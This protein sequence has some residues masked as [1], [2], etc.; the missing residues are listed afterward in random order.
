VIPSFDMAACI[1]YQNTHG[2][3]DSG[4]KRNCFLSSALVTLF[5]CADDEPEI[6]NIMQRLI[7]IILKVLFRICIGK[8]TVF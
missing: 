2:F 3:A 1:Q 7:E 4:G 8:F 6:I 5:I